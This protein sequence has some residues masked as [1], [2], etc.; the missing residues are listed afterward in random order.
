MRTPQK[1]HMVPKSAGPFALGAWARARAEALE[2][3]DGAS[4][5]QLRGAGGALTSLVRV[6]QDH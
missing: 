1:G 6:T 5:T 4:T 2:P 3:G